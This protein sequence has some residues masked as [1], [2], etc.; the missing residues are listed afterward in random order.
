MVSGYDAL[1]TYCVPLEVAVE[2]GI[3]GLIAFALLLISL[4]ARAHI[5]FWS[6]NPDK[7]TRLSLEQWLTA[8][9]VAALVGLLAQGMVDTVF[10]RPQVQY[11]F[12][13]VVAL[14]V[15]DNRGSSSIKRNS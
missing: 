10:Y 13:L 9:A 11:I 8:G 3:V 1:G 7:S 15:T 4:F 2:C 12:W 14:I 5:S 6:V